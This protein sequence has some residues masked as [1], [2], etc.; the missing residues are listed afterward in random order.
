MNLHIRDFP[1]RIVC[2]VEEP[3]EILYE[4]GEEDRIVGI[5]AYTVRPERAK[6]EKPVVSAFI[7]GSV[8]KICALEPDLIIGFSDIQGELAKKLIEANQQVLIFNQRTIQDILDV[9]VSIG[10]IVGKE[11]RAKELARGYI[12]RLEA[13][14]ARTD[15]QAHRP[16]VY[17][18]EWPDPQISAI[19]WVSQLVELAGGRDIFSEKSHGKGAKE[20]YVD[21]AG[22]IEHAPEAIIASWC[23]KPVDCDSIRNREGYETV[24]AVQ[25]DEIYELDPSI[26]L[27]PGPAALTDGLDALEAIIRPLAE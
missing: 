12:E 27:Q 16:P 7:G 18:E 19:R 17:F 8:D 22:V 26:I 14:K 6:D 25:N 20:R 9:I 11:E 13:A 5:S 21:H 4:L 15:A 24:P 10:R 3:T 1:E 2:L 23:G